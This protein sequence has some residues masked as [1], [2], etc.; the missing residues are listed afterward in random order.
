VTTPVSGLGQHEDVVEVTVGLDALEATTE[1]VLS[2]PAPQ[3]RERGR[4][5][6]Q[7]NDWPHRLAP[8]RTLIDEV[9]TD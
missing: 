7:A 1:R 9:L 5:L 4:Q 3:R 2:E 8:L 6:A